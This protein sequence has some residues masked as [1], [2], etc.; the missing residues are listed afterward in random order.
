MNYTRFKKRILIPVAHLRKTIYNF[1]AS[2]KGFM[3][4]MFSDM[5][6]NCDV[7]VKELGILLKDVSEE[8]DEHMRCPPV[9]SCFIQNVSKASPVCALF[10]PSNK[11]SSLL[12]T[13]KK[14]DLKRN[15]RMLRELQTEVP[16]LFDLVTKLEIIPDSFYSLLD[17]LIER[18]N[19]PFVNKPDIGTSPIEESSL[20]FYPQMPL[21]RD[22]GIY[23]QDA[24]G[25][26]GSC[27]K[28]SKGHPTLLPGI[29]T[30]YCPHGKYFLICILLVNHLHHLF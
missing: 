2:K 30:A 4:D 7:H 13:L 27:T 8:V 6:E 16:I 15:V 1:A 25:W 3:M 19:A 9:W 11:L 18:A 21:C 12:L 23:G 22:R 17:I 29:F 28:L 5:I 14:E 26:K 20:C 10:H 24:T